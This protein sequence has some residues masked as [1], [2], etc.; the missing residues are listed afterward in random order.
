MYLTKEEENILKGEKGEIYSKALKVIIKVGEA[1][2]ADR[3]IKITHSHISGISYLNIGDAGLDFIEN[4]A[5]NNAKVSV[6]TTAN[7]YAIMDIVF[8]GRKV[9]KDFVEKQR[10]I[11]NSLI[12][13]GIRNF[14]CTPYYV[15][16]PKRGEHLSWAE[17]NAVL[18]ANSVKGAK[19]NR[20]GGPLALFSS[21][22]GRTYYGGLHIDENRE[23]K[24]R[25][26]VEANIDLNNIL[27]AGILGYLVGLKAN[28]E[29]P[30]VEGIKRIKEFALR[31]FLAGVGTSSNLGLVI[32]RNVSPESK[33][34]SKENLHNLERINIEAYDIKEFMDGNLINSLPDVFITGCPHLDFYDVIN[35]VNNLRDLN[36]KNTEIWIITS[37]FVYNKLSSLRFFDTLRERNIRIIKDVC[38]IVSPLKEL[39]IKKVATDS[40]KAF[41]YLSRLTGIKEVKLASLDNL[42]KLLGV[43]K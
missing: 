33:N 26:I 5:E 21:L 10:R 29:I 36:L 12:S 3:L 8:K 2:G 40:V 28:N 7:P 13:I 6:F 22:V 4:I 37:T 35:T 39:G 32:I 1:I 9:R 16:P 14:T 19:T 17:S 20:E 15:R 27:Y 11:I 31:E 41:Y 18:Y 43:S 42:K 38:P 30:Y 25:I 23:P 24:L 34:Y